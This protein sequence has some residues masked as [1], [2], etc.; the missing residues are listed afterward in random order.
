MFTSQRGVSAAARL[1]DASVPEHLRIAVVGEATATR[2]RAL[3]GYVDFTAGAPNAAGL[4]RELAEFLTGRHLKIV[5]ALAENAGDVLA[6][7]LQAAGQQCLRFDVY[8]TLPVAP[9]SRRRPL[10][11][12]G[13]GIVFLASPS[14]VLGFV[15]Q[16]EIDA[17][18]R[19]ISIGPTTTAAIE[20]AGLKVHAQA[21]TPSLGGM[22]E[23][24]KD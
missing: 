14:A 8:R 2:T 20:R 6:E 13:A 17:Q 9:Q 11:E 21:P 23:A 22:L 5:L 15:N 1:L 7:T 10:S 16:I 19:L 3:F 4:A 12:I 24:I 18:A